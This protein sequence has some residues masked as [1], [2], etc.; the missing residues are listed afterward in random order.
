MEKT[1]IRTEVHYSSTV[2]S[3]S[4]RPSPLND[5]ITITAGD[6]A[7]IKQHFYEVHSLQKKVK[8]NKVLKRIMLPLHYLQYLSGLQPLQ[9]SSHTAYD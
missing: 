7:Q 6:L 5:Q 1:L 2:N 4:L 3:P 8:L 9:Y